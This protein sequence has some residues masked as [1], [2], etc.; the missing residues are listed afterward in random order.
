MGSVSGSARFMDVCIATVAAL[1]VLSLGA[2]PDARNRPLGAECSDDGECASGLCYLA[3]CIDPAADDDFDTLPN[4]YEVGL[5][6]NPRA[7]DSDADGKPDVAEV[8]GLLPVDSDGDGRA[9]IIESALADSD[10]DCLVDELDPDDEEPAPDGCNAGPV[11]SCDDLYRTNPGR[12]SGP[13][14]IDPD[15]DGPEAAIT[16]ECALGPASGGAGRLDAAYRPV[17]AR[18][19]A[20]QRRY[21]LL[22]NA[23]PQ[24]WVL[25][26]PTTEVFDFRVRTHV[27]G[28]WFSATAD[29]R[30]DAFVCPPLAT[31]NGVGIGCFADVGAYGSGSAVDAE[32]GV[33]EV[34]AA[35]VPG[36]SGCVTATAYARDV[37]CPSDDG[38]LM[39]GEFD[40]L[41]A[42]G[43]T[44]W[45]VESLDGGGGGIGGNVFIDAEGAR[46]GAAPAL[47]AE[48][49]EPTANFPWTVMFSHEDL[50]FAAGHAYRLVFWARAAA[51]RQLLV[52]IGAGDGFVEYLF[53]DSEWHAYSID[54]AATTT[55]LDGRLGLYLGLD[56]LGTT[57]WLDGFS[58]HELGADAC[59]RKAGELVA[60]GDFTYGVACFERI[61][62]TLGHYGDLLADDDAPVSAPSLRVEQRGEL[63]ESVPYIMQR[64]LP[65]ISGH[66]Y[67]LSFA[68][69]AAVPRTIDLIVTAD[70]PVALHV[71]AT[72]A[73]ATSWQTHHVRMLVDPAV[74]NP[75]N[76]LMMFIFGDGGNDTVW[77]DDLSV[78]DL[79]SDPCA[80]RAPELTG[81]GGFDLGTRCWSPVT[82]TLTS[83]E[84]ENFDET[85]G[86]APVLLFRNSAGTASADLGISQS[87]ALSAVAHTISLRAKARELPRVI[88]VRVMSSAGQPLFSQRLDLSDAWADYPLTFPNTAADA[89][90]VLHV[91]V[92]GTSDAWV[93]LDEV[94]L[95]KAAP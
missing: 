46:P 31:K 35:G 43:R 32:A 22:S 64:D 82:A 34:C 76:A 28:T 25:S 41:G 91:D 71:Q 87:V 47:R 92:G 81:D 61:R 94:H 88:V 33:L 56:E 51:P 75:G 63:E 54:F 36:L 48:K 14:T 23:N 74:A 11:T 78:V 37:R 93:Y 65:L 44:C 29:G 16:I 80:R 69:A 66:A 12:A 7:V 70:N 49:Y 55:A 30:I 4:G 58:L 73:L 8:P 42:G 79:G 21:L 18:A 20:R 95:Q 57:L 27:P 40:V 2:C 6:A 9:N 85:S 52:D 83:I 17:L 84:S 10:G 90:A 38:L 67:D 53:V 19:G 26:P 59:A 50:A 24:A 68:A 13:Q 72:R 45:K 15:G 60:G 86:S 3:E 62:S 77:L 1:T 39:D 89:N 5:E